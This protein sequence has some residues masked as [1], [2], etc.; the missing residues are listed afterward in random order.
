MLGLLILSKKDEF[1][2][3]MNIIILQLGWLVVEVH[4]IPYMGLIF[5]KFNPF[6]KD[7]FRSAKHE[8]KNIVTLKIPNFEFTFISTKNQSNKK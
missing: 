6:K 5:F 4:L 1:N 8:T 7:C 3:N 2:K